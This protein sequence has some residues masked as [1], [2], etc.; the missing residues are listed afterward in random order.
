MRMKFHPLARM[1]QFNNFSKSSFTP[2]SYQSLFYSPLVEYARLFGLNSVFPVFS[3]LPKERNTKTKNL[4]T[5][6]TQAKETGCQREFENLSSATVK[7]ILRHCEVY[8]LFIKMIVLLKG[9]RTIIQNQL[10]FPVVYCSSTY[11]SS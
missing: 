11:K 6:K 8:R 4:S 7:P 10:A 3:S 9:K 5:E 2:C 1:S